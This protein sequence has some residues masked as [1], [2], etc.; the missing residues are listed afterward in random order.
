M[1]NELLYADDLVL[2]SDSM[3]LFNLKERFLNWKDTLESVLW[4]TPKK[5]K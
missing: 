2:M 1:V 4:S 3:V 5:Q